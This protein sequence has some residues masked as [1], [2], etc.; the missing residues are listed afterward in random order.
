LKYSICFCMIKQNVLMNIFWI[1]LKEGFAPPEDGVVD[2]ETIEYVQ[3]D[4]N[5]LV[6]G[7]DEEEF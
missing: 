7:G 3:G 6:A 1:I 4:E 2:G 5:A